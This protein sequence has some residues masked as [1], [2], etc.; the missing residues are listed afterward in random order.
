M[1][2][3]DRFGQKTVIRFSRL[4]RSPKF[5]PNTFSF[6]VPPGVDVVTE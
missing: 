4:E 5:A 3:Y 1:E 2:L 6:R